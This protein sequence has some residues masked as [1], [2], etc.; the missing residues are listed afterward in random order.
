MMSV[1]MEGAGLRVFA[2]S[3]AFFSVLT[4][5]ISYAHTNSSMLLLLYKNLYSLSCMYIDWSIPRRCH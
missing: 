3:L 5:T 4:Y 1:E 2:M